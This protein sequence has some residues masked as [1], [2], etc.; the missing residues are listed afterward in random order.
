MPLDGGAIQ[1]IG[2]GVVC[3]TGDSKIG[4]SRI[5][6]AKR[7]VIQIVDLDTDL[8]IDVD[9]SGV[10]CLS[11]CNSILCIAGTTHVF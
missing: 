5:A 8:K 11:L 4:S 6:I 10:I 3:V 9:V 7:R 1:V 2:K